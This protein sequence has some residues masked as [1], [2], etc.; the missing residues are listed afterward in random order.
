M[1]AELIVYVAQRM[2]QLNSKQCPTAG[3]P[4]NLRCNLPVAVVVGSAPGLGS[5]TGSHR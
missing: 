4:A 3:C 1:L 5:L 2:E